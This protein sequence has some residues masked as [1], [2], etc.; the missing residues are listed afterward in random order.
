[1]T[2]VS[3]AAPKKYW[4]LREMA[5]SPFKFSRMLRTWPL[6]FHECSAKRQTSMLEC[7]ECFEDGSNN[8]RMLHEMAASPFKFDECFTLGAKSLRML[9]ETATSAIE[10][11]SRFLRPAGRPPPWHARRRHLRNLAVFELLGSLCLPNA[12]RNGEIMC[13]IR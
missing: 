5:E 6:T 11:Q 9:R 4:M 1:M 7:G 8:C 10:G 13:Q 12:P 3:N 2:N